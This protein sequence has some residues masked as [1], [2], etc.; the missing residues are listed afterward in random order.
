MSKAHFPSSLS[1][2]GKTCHIRAT[3]SEEENLNQ[4]LRDITNLAIRPAWVPSG[5]E[6]PADPPGS[7]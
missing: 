4:S 1:Q 6:I 5:L 2:P 7:R 3:R